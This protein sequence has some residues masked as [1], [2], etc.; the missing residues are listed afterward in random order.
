M[1]TTTIKD[2]VD[3]IDHIV[4]VAGIDH[5][6]LGSNFDGVVSLPQNLEN[7]SCFPFVTQELLNRGYTKEQIQ[8]VLGGNALRVLGTVESVA[9]NGKAG[10]SAS[11]TVATSLLK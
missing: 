1:P 10:S 4:N 9:K 7:V 3:H 6:G 2:V 8:K 5:V 11:A